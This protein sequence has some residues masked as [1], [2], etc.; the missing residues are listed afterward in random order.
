MLDSGSAKL[1]MKT[2]LA[3]DGGYPKNLKLDLDQ[4]KF[5]NLGQGNIRLLAPAGCGKTHSLLWRCLRLAER[6]PMDKPRLLLFTFTRSARD[7]LL[8][9]L[10]TQADFNPIKGLVS[11]TTL[12]AWGFRFIKGKTYNLRLITSKKDRSFCLQNNLQPIWQRHDRLRELLTDN[13]RK[14]RATNPIMDLIDTLKSLGFRHDKIK[15]DEDL[16][17]HM[18]YLLG[19]G[20]KSHIVSIFKTLGDLEIIKSENDPLGEMMQN[21]ITFWQEATDQLYQSALLSLDDQK[22][23]AWIE[24]EKQLDQGRYTTGGGRYHF[25]LVDE[26]QD[27]NP[28]DLSLLKIIAAI[29]KANLTIIGDDDQAIYEWRGATPTFILDPN[30]HIGGSYETCILGVNYR[31]PRNIVNLSQQLIAHN[32]RRVPK[33]VRPAFAK[34]AVIELKRFADLNKCIDFVLSLVRRFLKDPEC[35][36]IALIGRKRSQIIPYQIVFAGQKI[37]FYAAEDLHVLLSD[38]FNELKEILAIRSRTEMGG[39]PGIDPVK[40]ILTMCD[41][42]KRFPLAKKDREALNRHLHNGNPQTLKEA[43]PLLLKYAGPLKGENLGGRMSLEFASAVAGL[44]GAKTVAQSIEAIS[45]N[46]DGLRK[47]YGK[48]LEDIFYADPPFL[49]LAEY[50]QRYGNDYRTFY[51]DIEQAIATLARIPP[52]DEESNPDIGWKLPLHLM[53]ALRAKG[54]EFDAVIVLDANNGI[55]P[56]KLATT[57]DELEQER[58]L[59]YVAMTRARKYLYFLMDDSILGEPAIPSPYLAEMGVKIE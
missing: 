8:D 41:K 48:S 3:S 33:E 28:L 24:L 35:H 20:M 21:F 40:D 56:S 22:Y 30:K 51:R 1:N 2:P 10:R 12:N 45:D 31:S 23:W 34:D 59:F 32:K 17:K 36:N 15:S 42:V 16:A 19:C 39:V 58:R 38:A 43:I 53:T 5:C 55:W 11:V 13:R 6:S 46:Y 9:R 27:I 54:K 50:A 18:K 49:Y 29:N 44:I 14:Y 47:D 25:I 4:E 52:E 7:E 26:F 57:E 37:P